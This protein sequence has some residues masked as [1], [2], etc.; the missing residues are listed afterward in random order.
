[1]KV[2]QFSW[3]PAGKSKRIVGGCRPAIRKKLSSLCS[4]IFNYRSYRMTRFFGFLGLPPGISQRRYIEQRERLGYFSWKRRTAKKEAEVS[5]RSRRRRPAFLPP[6][7][8]L[9]FFRSPSPASAAKVP[10]ESASR[11]LRLRIRSLV[12]FGCPH[13]RLIDSNRRAGAKLS[14]LTHGGADT[15]P[16]RWC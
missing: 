1:M 13:L 2:F 6:P 12:N 3:K 10:F 11:T 7:P 16:R 8:Q 9:L 5:P 14:N 4:A 15:W